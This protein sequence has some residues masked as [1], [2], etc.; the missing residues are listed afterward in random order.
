MRW[1]KS[2]L[3]WLKRWLVRLLKASLLAVLAAGLSWGAFQLWH[4]WQDHEQGSL[5]KVKL[6][7]DAKHVNEEDIRQLLK[8]QLGLGFWQLDLPMIRKIIETDPWVAHAEV[9]RFW[10]NSL[11]VEIAEQVPVARWGSNGLLNQIGEIFYPP[12]IDEA[13]TKDLIQLSAI[14]PEPREVLTMLKMVLAKINPYGLH[15]NALHRQADGSWHLFLINGDEWLLP[16]QDA[17]AKMDRLLILYG[18]ISKQEN[19]NMRVDLRYRDGFAVKW[20]PKK[21]VESEATAPVQP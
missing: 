10:P 4:L 15:L 1:L 8:P 21:Q 2:L 16:K 9:S 14:N 20:M 17:L 11:H 7:T 3:S 13:E 19:S 18:S 12:V 6:L 5:V